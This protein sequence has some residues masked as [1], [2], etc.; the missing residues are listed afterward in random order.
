MTLERLTG[1]HIG[2]SACADAQAASMCTDMPGMGHSSAP[3]RHDDGYCPLCP[4]LHL[5]VVVL[6]LGL[7]V[8][9]A[10]L[11]VRYSLSRPAELCLRLAN[12]I[13]RARP[14]STGPPIL[15]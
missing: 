5:P 4:L 14:P 13:G 3:H 6:A 7:A 15:P 10:C 1:L 2:P 9:L 11:R 12:S 8:L